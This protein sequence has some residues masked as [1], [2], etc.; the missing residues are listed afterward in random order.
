MSLLVELG[1]VLLVQEQ[2]VSIGVKVQSLH[3]TRFL[4]EPNAGAV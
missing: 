4:H 1:L 3:K 2:T